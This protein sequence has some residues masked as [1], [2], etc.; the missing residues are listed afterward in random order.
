MT[1]LSDICFSSSLF[2][3]WYFP[4]HFVAKSFWNIT[5]RDWEVYWPPR[6]EVPRWSLSSDTIKFYIGILFLFLEYSF[7]LFLCWSSS[8]TL[9][10]SDWVLGHRPNSFQCKLYLWDQLAP[11]I[12]IFTFL[13]LFY[14]IFKLSHIL[15]IIKLFIF[16]FFN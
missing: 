3:I 11:T 8:N 9:L 6:T 4:I 14:S 10:F 15:H 12:Y 13:I 16:S 5:L 1:V 2:F 7:H